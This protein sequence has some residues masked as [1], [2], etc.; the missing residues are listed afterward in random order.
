LFRK[1]ALQSDSIKIYSGMLNNPSTPRIVK[2]NISK[3]LVCLVERNLETRYQVF[4]EAIIPLLHNIHEEMITCIKEAG[5]VADNSSFSLNVFGNELSIT[6]GKEIYDNVEDAVPNAPTTSSFPEVKP[7]SVPNFAEIAWSW[8]FSMDSLAILFDSDL[9]CLGNKEDIDVYAE[10]FEEFSNDLVSLVLASFGFATRQN[11]LADD[12]Y[13]F[14]L[15]CSGTKLLKSLLLIR[16]TDLFSK[17][18]TENSG[19]GS[20]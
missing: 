10:Q 8:K 4:F 9:L 13:N 1:I 19:V 11:G 2:P 16:K 5:I 6:A 14:D 15:A 17:F 12:A 18:C 20:F 7:P 3:L